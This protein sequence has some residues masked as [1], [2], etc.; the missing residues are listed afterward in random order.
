MRDQ[1]HCA[2]RG[3]R[4][5]GHTSV[6]AQQPAESFVALTNAIWNRFPAYP[7]YE[8]AHDVLIPHLTVSRAPIDL[9]IAL[10]IRGTARELTLIQETD[11]RWSVRRVFPLQGVA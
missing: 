7:P 8:G 11:G 6:A 4:P 2:S 5:S 10:P 3:G 9:E 1:R